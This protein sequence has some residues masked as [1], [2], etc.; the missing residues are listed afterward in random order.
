MNPSVLPSRED[1][2]TA[3]QQGEAAVLAVFDVLK[4][5]GNLTARNQALEDQIAKNKVFCQPRSYIATAHKDGQRVLNVL[6]QALSETP[7]MPSF[8][9]VQLTG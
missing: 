1:M 9:P 5:I 2:H 8:L 4:A 6:V 7:Y 3:H